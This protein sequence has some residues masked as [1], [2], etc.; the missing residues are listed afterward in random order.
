MIEFK[1]ET[2][3][4]QRNQQCLNEKHVETVMIE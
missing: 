4:E 3:S 2:T 1:M